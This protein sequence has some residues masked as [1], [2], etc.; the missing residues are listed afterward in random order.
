MTLAWKPL[1]GKSDDAMTRLLFIKLLRDME[2]LWPRIVLMIAAMSITLIVFSGVLYTRG[3]TGREMPG[4]YLST[5]PAS[6]TILLERKLDAGQMASIATE[7]RKQP[8]VI[9]ATARTQFTLQVQ[10]E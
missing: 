5:S 2:S 4:A 7:V 9:N 8:G 1:P 6:A 3:V 10:Q